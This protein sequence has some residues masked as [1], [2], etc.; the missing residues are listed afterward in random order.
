MRTSCVLLYVTLYLALG[1]GGKGAH[2]PAV[3]P[4][5]VWLPS[6]LGFSQQAP[7]ACG[8]VLRARVEPCGRETV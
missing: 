6:V 7:P 5:W 2:T 1:L 3:T 4:G 8:A